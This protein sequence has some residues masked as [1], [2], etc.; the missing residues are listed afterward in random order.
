MDYKFKVKCLPGAAKKTKAAR[1]AIE[2]FMRDTTT[3]PTEKLLL[4]NITDNELNTVL[5]SNVSIQLP[6]GSSKSKFKG[7]GGKQKKAKK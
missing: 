3:T 7:K 4:K 6:G 2:Y 1:G 5:L